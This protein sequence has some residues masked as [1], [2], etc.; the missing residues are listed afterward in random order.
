[1]NALPEIPAEDVNTDG[2]VDVEDLVD[3]AS[4]FG[5]SIPKGTYPNPDVN[6]DGVVN[7]KDILRV[8]AILEAAAGGT[9]IRITRLRRAHRRKPT[10][11]D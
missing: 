1:M 9:C 6:A 3:V 2:V 10:I 4:S 8:I 11:L 7:R 5:K